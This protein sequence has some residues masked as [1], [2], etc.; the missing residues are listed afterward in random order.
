[1]RPTIAL[2]E[3]FKLI[4]KSIVLDGYI[5]RLNP[6]FTALCRIINVQFAKLTMFEHRDYMLMSADTRCI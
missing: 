5:N 1:M 3:R 2:S 6:T 4:Q